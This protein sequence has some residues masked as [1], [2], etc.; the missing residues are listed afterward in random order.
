[1]AAKRKTIEQYAKELEKLSKKLTVVYNKLVLAFEYKLN[2]DLKR[3]SK[4]PAKKKTT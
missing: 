3:I 4:A 2:Q 1:M